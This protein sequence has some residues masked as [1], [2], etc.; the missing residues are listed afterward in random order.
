MPEDKASST[1]I[2]LLRELAKDFGDVVFM[3]HCAIK[4]VSKNHQLFLVL[5]GATSLLW[6]ATQQQLTEPVTQDFFREWMH[7]HSCKPKWVV[8][9][10]AFFTPSWMTFWTTHGVKTMP[11][12]RATPWPKRAE[13]AARLFKRQYE[14]LLMWM[15]CEYPRKGCS[16]TGARSNFEIRSFEFGPLIRMPRATR[17]L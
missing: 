11:T 10:M 9:D 13:T 3:D 8:A 14:K 2:P 6:G 15:D 1:E 7:I 17:R 12:G 4:H 5:D 16:R